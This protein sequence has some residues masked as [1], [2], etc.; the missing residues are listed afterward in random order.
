[1]AI[2]CLKHWGAEELRR[3]R[4]AELDQHSGGQARHKQLECRFCPTLTDH[5]PCH[6]DP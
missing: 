5:D 3:K 6:R 1:M 2:P 4:Y